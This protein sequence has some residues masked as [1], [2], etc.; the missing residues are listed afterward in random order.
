MRTDTD[1][2]HL[3]SPGTAKLVEQAKRDAD[4]IIERMRPA[5]EL[6]RDRMIRLQEE[7]AGP[8]SRMQEAAEEFHKHAKRWQPNFLKGWTVSGVSIPM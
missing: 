5:A 8:R 1:V 4:E 2:Q 6:F 7:I 3:P